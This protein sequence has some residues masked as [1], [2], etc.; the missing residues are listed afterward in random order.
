MSQQTM[1]KWGRG[2]LGAAINSAASAVTVV[3]VD[4]IAFNPLAG[5]ITKLVSVMI[6]AAL[7]GA[8]LYLKNHPLPECDDEPAKV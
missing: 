1:R 8:A 2:L 6:V 4:P 3:V 7:F 5:G